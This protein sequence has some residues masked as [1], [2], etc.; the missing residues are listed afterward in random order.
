MNI[1]AG[2][3]DKL[4]L[5]AQPTFLAPQHIPH[6]HP[7]QFSPELIPSCMPLIHLLATNPEPSTF[8]NNHVLDEGQKA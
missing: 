4:K 1:V 2:K 8:W 3:E 7:S 6:D 5:H